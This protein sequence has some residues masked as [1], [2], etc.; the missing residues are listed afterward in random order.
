M[1][2]RFKIRTETKEGG[3][4]LESQ[5]LNPSKLCYLLGSSSLVRVSSLVMEEFSL[6]HGLQ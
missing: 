5:G 1:Q 6:L 4:E 2:T 3:V